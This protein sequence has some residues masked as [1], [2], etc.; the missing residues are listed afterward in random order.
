MTFLSDWFTPNFD[1]L[2]FGATQFVGVFATFST[3]RAVS[4]LEALLEISYKKN[5]TNQ[6]A[7]KQQDF[8]KLF[9]FCFSMD[10]FIIVA[11]IRDNKHI[12]CLLVRPWKIVLFAVKEIAALT[13]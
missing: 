13:L 8:L 1:G 3:Y 6:C 4:F 7:E 5:N 11:V 12:F 9:T 10:K 2:L